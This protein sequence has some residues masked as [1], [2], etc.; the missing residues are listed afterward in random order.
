MGYTGDQEDAY[1]DQ[2]VAAGGNTLRTWG[3][4]QL[5]E[6]LLDKA[7]ER[8]LTVA[9]R[10]RQTNNL[11]S[12]QDFSGQRERTTSVRQYRLTWR[13]CRPVQRRPL[14]ALAGN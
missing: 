4:E 8:G 2:L 9:E 6:N 14:G 10:Q 1:L 7:H 11:L 3:V 13:P 5:G 12:R